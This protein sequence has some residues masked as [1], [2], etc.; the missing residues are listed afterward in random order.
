MTCT[1]REEKY[2][3]HLLG[4]RLLASLCPTD[5]RFLPHHAAVTLWILE[6]DGRSF[7]FYDALASTE[8]GDG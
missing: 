4:R 6:D 3:L 7:R 5:L 2:L 1:T 8:E